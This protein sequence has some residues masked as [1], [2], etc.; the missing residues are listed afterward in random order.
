MAA[1]YRGAAE[2]TQFGEQALA[3]AAGTVWWRADALIL[4]R[5][6]DLA[7]ADSERDANAVAA[8]AAVAAMR[9]FVR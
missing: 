1:R 5:Q 7:I 8:V 9:V 4:D 2:R 6:F 3:V